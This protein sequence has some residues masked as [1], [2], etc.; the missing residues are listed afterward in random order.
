MNL[1]KNNKNKKGIYMMKN[2]NIFS[3]TI[4]H[5]LVEDLHITENTPFMVSFENG[6]IT[7]E[8]LLEESQDNLFDNEFDCT[9]SYVDGYADG[10]LQGYT[11]GYSLGFDDAT[12]GRSFNNAYRS[13]NGS[14]YHNGVS[15]D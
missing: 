1:M 5:H 2:R 8:P 15:E 13:N 9:P 4:P 14:C 11:N 6:T 12:A 3:F 7:I 10:I